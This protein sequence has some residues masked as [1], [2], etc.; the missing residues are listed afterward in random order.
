M[1]V[2]LVAVGRVL[3]SEGGRIW[4]EHGRLPGGGV[5]TVLTAVTALRLLAADSADTIYQSIDAG[6]TG[7]PSTSRHR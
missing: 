6:R 3:S 5:P 1:L 7:R 2:A 4:T